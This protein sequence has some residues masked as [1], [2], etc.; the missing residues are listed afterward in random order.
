M[1]ENGNVIY[2]THELNYKHNFFYASFYF[3]S[4]LKGANAV[5]HI[6]VF[7]AQ[8]HINA[9]GLIHHHHDGHG[10]HHIQNIVLI[11]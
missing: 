7:Q 2:A 8:T 10:Q 1:N 9:Y 11:D 6:K 4:M 5:I 3:Q